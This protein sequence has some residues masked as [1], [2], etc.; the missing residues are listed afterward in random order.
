MRKFIVLVAAA[1]VFAAAHAA[2]PTEASINALLVAGKTEKVLDG[3]YTYVTQSMRQ[4]MHAALS[5]KQLTD[6]QKN[7]LDAVP[8]KFEQVMR[9]EMNWDKLRPLYVQIYRETFT[10]S[11]IDG[12][13]AFYKS[14]TG[15]AYIDKM[16]VVMQKS[17]K[18]MQEHFAPLAAKMNAA[19]E[20][21]ISDA[22]A[23]K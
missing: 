14:P 11:E 15:S 1:A 16:P 6:A 8:T 12:L 9:Q 20:Q 17:Q 23:A 7:A 5:D 3:F 19:V 4:G 22:R 2:T 18:M 10:Q 13:T 21:A